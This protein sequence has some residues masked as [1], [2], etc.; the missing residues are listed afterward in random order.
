MEHRSAVIQCQVCCRAGNSPVLL[1]YDLISVPEA[2]L[3]PICLRLMVATQACLMAIP[4]GKESRGGVF[5][6]LQGKVKKAH[7]YTCLGWKQGVCVKRT[8]LGCS[9]KPASFANLPYVFGP[10]CLKP[11]TLWNYKGHGIAKA[12]LEKN[13]VGGM[14]WLISKLTTKLEQWKLFGT[15]IGQRIRTESLEIT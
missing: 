8:D 12:V 9:L 14:Q 1:W 2:P 5:F 7:L 15:D 11:G 4:D 6:V 3:V 13:K 10:R